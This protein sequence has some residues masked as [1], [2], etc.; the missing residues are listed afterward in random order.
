M[1]PA[2]S[3]NRGKLAIAALTF[4]LLASSLAPGPAAE[5]DKDPFA[6][7]KELFT[8]E[9]LAGDRRSF[10]GDGLGPLYNA[11]SCAACHHL[12]GIGGAGPKGTNATI[13]SVFLEQKEPTEVEVFGLKLRAKPRPP[14]QP[15]RA[16]LAE[17]H[18]A[19]RTDNSFPFHRFGT[20]EEFQ[21]WKN[22]WFPIPPQIGGSSMGFIN[23]E[24]NPTALFGAALIDRIPNEVL[25]E[26]A[27]SQARA[28]EMIL[29]RQHRQEGQFLQE[30]ELPMGRIA[31]L[32][33]GRIGRFGWKAQTATLRE[34]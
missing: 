30:D 5:K 11:R 22:K 28:A 14:Q 7:G 3:L 1:K 20:E 15:D 2:N 18:P 23:S 17:I 26:V 34:F 33:D 4:G 27:A 25:E 9:W 10:A 13:A 16:K 21:Q 29:Q 6:E 19:L 32:K 24:R 8:R 31:R 12:G